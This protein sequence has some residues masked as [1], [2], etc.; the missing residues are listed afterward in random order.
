MIQTGDW[1]VPRQ[2]GMIYVSRP[3]LG[4]WPI[5]VLA[6]VRGRLDVFSIRLPSL[7]AVL[8]TAVLVYGYARI[9][10]TRL[11]AFTAG[12][13]YPT[14]AQVLQIGRLAETE[15]FFALL[16]AGS[17]FLW[18]AGYLRRWPM[19][20]TWSA[21]YTLAGAAGLTKGPQGPL[22]FVAVTWTFLIVRRDWRWFFSRHHLVGLVPFAAIVGTWQVLYFWRTDLQS[23]IAIWVDQAANRFQDHSAVEFSRHLATYPLEILACMLPWSLLLVQLFNPR[24]RRRLTGVWRPVVFLITALAVTFPSVWWAAGARGRYY[25]PLYPLV[26]VFVGLIAERCWRAS[27]PT[28]ER[29]GWRAFFV[30]SSV[31]AVGAAGVVC[32]AGVIDSPHLRSLAQPPM[33][34]AFFAL[35]SWVLAACLLQAASARSMVKAK[36]GVWALGAFLGLTYSG[37]VVNCQMRVM[38]DIGAS[39][40][41]AKE[42][43]P[44]GVPLVSLGV[45]HHTF[46]YHFGQPIP[47]VPWSALGG[48][49]DCEYFCFDDT[50]QKRK[51][52]PWKWQP[53]ARVSVD[54]NCSAETAKDAVMLGRRIQDG[55]V[56]LA[57]S[58]NR[59]ARH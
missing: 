46:R 55:A 49:V 11:G 25:M 22:Y 50:P 59:R 2:Q 6:A 56:P 34:A 43:L 44:L 7:T 14:M 35:A 18:H 36:A 26:A 4:S 37:V 33:F 9:Y 12:V 29:L 57:E 13:A 27:G 47:V 17:L 40:A 5:A 15:A 58:T 3:P 28:W 19:W 23:A 20:L 42:R 24:F 30:G 31:A 48:T 21:G 54:K 45:V 10:L 41:A 52:I 16:V 38:H 53:V 8:L 1:V 32:L 39:V 51:S